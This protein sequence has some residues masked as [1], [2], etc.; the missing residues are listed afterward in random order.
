MSELESGSSANLRGAAVAVLT[1]LA[2][3]HIV[4]AVHFAVV[5]HTFALG[6]VVHCDW[7]HLRD[8]HD[9]KDGDSPRP[10]PSGDECQ[11]FA[12]LH[13]AASFPDALLRVT[14]PSVVSDH[15]PALREHAPMSPPWAL[16]LLAPSHS[17]PASRA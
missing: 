13:L 17:P 3:F 16:Y 4:A 12:V 2:I 6:R 7:D 10:S 8:T 1:F 14:A 5:P 11:V 9:K 15:V